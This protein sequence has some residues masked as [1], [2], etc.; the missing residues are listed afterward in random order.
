MFS[1]FS[2]RPILFWPQQAFKR[3][4]NQGWQKSFQH[5]IFELGPSGVLGARFPPLHPTKGFSFY[6]NK[7][8]LHLV[9]LAQSP[10][11]KVTFDFSDPSLCVFSDEDRQLYLPKPVFAPCRVCS[12]LLYHASFAITSSAMSAITSSAIGV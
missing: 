10:E 11:S 9:F 4:F 2:H 5:C 8:C 12:M 7:N 6:C 1:E 3:I